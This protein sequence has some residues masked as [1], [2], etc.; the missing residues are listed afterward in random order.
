M[1]KI[2]IKRVTQDGKDN[3]YSLPLYD[4]PSPL[5]LDSDLFAGLNEFQRKAVETI[6]GAVLVVAGA[7]SGKTRVLTYRI[8]YLLNQKVPA[9][10]ILALTFTN[11]AAAEMKERICKLVGENPSKSLWM[12][13]FHSVF[14]KI[15]RIEAEKIGFT[16][17]F[18]IYDTEDQQSV[19]K[20]LM[21]VHAI[22]TQ[23]FSPKLISS[24]ISSAKNSMINPHDY[25]GFAKDFMEEKIALVYDDYEKKLKA[26]NAMD[27][28]D[29]L[30]RTIELFDKFPEVLEKYQ[31]KF[32][33]IVIDEY[34]DTNR[35]QYTVVNML[36]AKSKNICVVG[37]DAQSIYKFRGADI[38]NILDFERDYSDVKI[39][40]LEQNYRSTSTILAAAD[41]VI[42]N[43]KNQISK[44]LWTENEEGEKLKVI[45]LKDEKDEA[46]EIV[47]IIRKKQNARISFNNIAILYRTNA[48]S[49]SIE[50]GLRKSS[51]PY[52]LVGGVP[53]YRRKEVKDALSY[54]KLIV[55]ERDNESFNRII[56]VPSRGI[57]DVSIKR[58]KSFADEKG[59]SLLDAAK[60]SDGI[61]DISSRTIN[62]IKKFAFM[63]ESYTSSIFPPTDTARNILS[64]SGLLQSYKDEGTPES[65]AR[66]ENVQSILSHLADF[67]EK[68]SN[69][70][71]SEYLQEVALIADIDSYDSAAEKV[72][73]MTIHS[74]KGLEF[75]TIIIAGMEEGLFPVGETAMVQEELEEE[76]RLCYVAITRAKNDLYI[77][78][79]E[80]RYRFG[81]LS[82]PT[83]SRFITEIDDKLIEMKSPFEK[84]NKFNS[85]GSYSN[86]L[87]NSENE[88]YNNNSTK[89]S[90][91]VKS[92]YNSNSSGASYYNDK[93]NKFINNY[94]QKNSNSPKN[95]STNYDYNSTNPIKN[96][97]PKVEK[98]FE[99]STIE[100]D[101]YSQVEKPIRTGSLV[102]HKLFGVGKVESL[103]GNGDKAKATIRFESVGRKM[104][105]LKFA[106]LKIIT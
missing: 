39:V 77:T 30:V 89:K 38:K 91:P 67:Y 65:L 9:Y 33:Y 37:D 75:D 51:I 73:M 17:N 12:G 35:A 94:S 101:D 20:Q 43:N 84:G 103:T 68:N 40:R 53:F 69:A 36:A 92:T 60:I 100:N 95:D 96:N 98:F 56:N 46:E 14:G 72:T 26:N 50:E 61:K 1:Q 99:D 71:L 52:T 29:L 41:S 55:N 104:L 66:W 23:D 83:P 57:G 74:A 34:Q 21:T 76:R 45:T 54:L 4:N 28:D 48:Q 25:S 97:P 32:K 10:S 86:L 79:C 15:L 58:L 105:M 93:F 106:N 82:Y 42:K 24:R 64:E 49:F 16:S 22:S 19:I 80:R 85:G 5:K 7:G 13:T 59:I 3:E 81:N 11:K 63:I 47:R 6:H 62:A 70:T 90:L 78:N 88:S 44:K 27:F 87:D 102:R 31:H 8:A 2:I 18:S